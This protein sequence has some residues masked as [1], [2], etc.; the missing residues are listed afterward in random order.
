MTYVKK[1]Y[2]WIAPL[3]VLIVGIISLVSIVHA[4]N[5][6]SADLELDNNESLVA[7]DSA[8]LSFADDFTFECGANQTV[9]P[10][11]FNPRATS[12]AK[13]LSSVA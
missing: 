1:R 5:T 8:S 6:R 9:N 3:A 13:S 2:L 11:A 12:D 7:P 10:L 4:A